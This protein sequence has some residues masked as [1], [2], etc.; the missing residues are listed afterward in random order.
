MPMTKKQI[1]QCLIDQFVDDEGVNA[2]CEAKIKES[3][4]DLFQDEEF[5]EEQQEARDSKYYPILASMHQSLLAEMIVS[6][7]SPM[8]RDDKE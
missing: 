6:L 1:L 4:P 3:Y 8:V 5:N 2:Y 7:G